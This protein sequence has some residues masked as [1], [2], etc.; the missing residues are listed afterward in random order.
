MGPLTSAQGL[1]VIPVRVPHVDALDDGRA[2]LQRVAGVAR[3]L[4]C[5]PDVIGGVGCGEVPILNVG[6]V[7]VAFLKCWGGGTKE[8]QQPKMSQG[9][10]TALYLRR[11]LPSCCS[12][13]LHGKW[14]P[15]PAV[16]FQLTC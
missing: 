7:T 12:G 6:L 9:P 15:D 14:V 2:L 8:G 5:G 11:W 10:P 3:E 13:K 4:H 16:Q 1:R